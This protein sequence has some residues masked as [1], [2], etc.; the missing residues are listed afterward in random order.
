MA[1]DPSKDTENYKN[2]NNL[3]AR[4]AVLNMMEDLDV[5]DVY[6][7]INPDE[8]R[9]SWRKKILENRQD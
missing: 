9:Y 7:H 3:K 5:I 6:R 8:K 1:L 2:I 4:R